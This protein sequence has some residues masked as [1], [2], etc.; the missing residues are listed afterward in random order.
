MSYESEYKALNDKG[1]LARSAEERHEV[2]EA[3][4]AFVEKFNNANRGDRSK[5]HR[6]FKAMVDS[7][8]GVA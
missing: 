4:R 1:K 3:K 7:A 6:A 5:A 8:N 2:R